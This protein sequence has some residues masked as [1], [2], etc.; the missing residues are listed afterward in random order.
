M[1]SWVVAALVT[2]SAVFCLLVIAAARRYRGGASVRSL[3]AAP[4]PPISILKPLAGADDGLEANL[5]S[6]FEQDYAGPFEILFAV[7]E[8]TDPAA[9]IVGQ[10]QSEH[11]LTPSRLLLVGEPP[12]PNAKVWSLERMTAE[13]R[14]ELLAMADSDIRVTPQFLTAVAAEFTADPQLAVTTCPY[15]AVAGASL[16]SQLEAMMMNTEFLAGILVARM[17]EGMRFA[18]GPT[19]VARKEAIEKIGGWPR[20]KDYLAEDFMLGQLA[21]EAGLGVGLSR[22]VIEHRIGSQPFAPN[23]RH[24]LR[25]CRST[26]RSRPAGYAG[27]LFT[28]ALPWILA[29]LPWS[30]LALPVWIW[31]KVETADLTLGDPLIRRRWYL[32]PFTELLSF[33]FWIGGF[34]GNTIAWRGR[35]YYLHRDGRF[36][37]IASLL[38]LLCSAGVAQVPRKE[39]VVVTGAYEPVAIEESDRAVRRQEIRADGE[40][41]VANSLVD[42][43][44]RDSSIDLRQRGGNNIQTDVSIRGATFGQTLVL[45]NGLRLNDVQTGHHSMDVP[46]PIESLERVEVLK[47]AGSTLYGSDAIGG[48]INFITATPEASEFRVRGA[49]GSFGTNQQRA[50]GTIVR[51]NFSQQLSAYRDFSTGFTPNRD[52]RNLALSS[53]SYLR[54][55]LGTSSI[56]LAYN[57]KPFGAEQFYGNFNS[58]ERTKTWWSSAQQS[59]G[60]RTQVSFAFRRHTDLFVLYRDRPQVFTNRHAVESYQG[61]LRHTEPLGA[62]TAVHWGVEAWRDAIVSSNLGNHSRARGSGYAAIDFRAL[63]RFSLSLGA[64]EEI[65]RALD[66][67]FVPSIAGGAWL[68]PTLKLRASASRAF[69]LPSFTDLYYQ[70]PGNRGSP[71]LRPESAWNYET[72]VDWN[73]SRTMRGELTLFHRRERD[74]IDYVRRSAAD[75]WRATNFQRL[76]FTGVEAAARLRLRGGQL[77]DFSYT[78]LRGAQNALAGAQSKYTF[79]YPNHLGVAGWQAALPGGWLARLR[80]G[81]VQRY[82]RDP[83]AVADIYAARG[84]GVVRPFFQLT[85]L[86]DAVYQE[87]FGVPMPGRAVLGGLE[88]VV[89]GRS[90]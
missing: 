72:G 86:N 73:P 90:N 10:L 48:V 89:G 1:L 60:E 32:L 71:D 11:P 38:L 56:V 22:Y 79:N 40:A 54:T 88:F 24:R 53:S 46:V 36:E 39:T 59:L 76:H 3:R 7:R 47:G 67:Q 55:R 65:Y 52:Y 49:L 6:F 45:L 66:A 26:R 34:F 18:V 85:N 51:R 4:A 84:R 61:S 42:F 58:W 29:G 35:S 23:A 12:Y 82:A 83:Y 5:R 28:Y 30:L 13:A 62:N 19:I 8:A 37:R 25:W 2:G 68:S 69:R 15:R 43:L 87:I 9:A 14:Y 31:S 16:W 27:Q 81:A 50:A 70:D 21:A 74:G 33:A 80:V 41:L 63:R 77:L 44:N 17:L 57:D 75:I 64:R 20:L 78:G